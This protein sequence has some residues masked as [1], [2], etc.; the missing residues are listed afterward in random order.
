MYLDNP[1]TD[2]GTHDL[3]HNNEIGSVQREIICMKRFSKSLL[4]K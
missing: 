4:L 1:L 3:S 2:E